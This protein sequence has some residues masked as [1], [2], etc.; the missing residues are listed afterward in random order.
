MKILSARR[1]QVRQTLK[2]AEAV[3]H[4]RLRRGLVPALDAETGKPVQSD[5]KLAVTVTAFGLAAGAI[6]LRVG[7]R[8][9]LVSAVGLD[10]I[11][12]SP[13]LKDNLEQVLTAAETMDPATKVALFVAAWTAVKVLC[14]DAG[15]VVLALAAGL[16]FG[17][18]LQGAVASAAAA[19]WGSCVAYTLAQLD[20]PV[21]QKALQLLQD[22]PSLRGIE[23]VVAKD[24]WK[25]V[26]TLRLA[27]VLPIPIGLYNYV[28]G[29]TNV[30][31]A[32]FAAG[33]FLGSLKPYLLDSYLG[34]FGK[35][36]IQG[37]GGGG[38]Q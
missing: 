30:P 17:G 21:R 19:T 12:E 38:R 22:Y 26:L 7:G 11:A 35:E 16:L 5:G 4:V 36:V 37:G 33:I 6:A 20:T 14:F 27:P 2:A 18:V 9:A 34:Y 10:F 3:R 8:A 1:Q 31:V 24:G 25:A 23:K 15:G 28:Y 29:V 32:Q 13:E